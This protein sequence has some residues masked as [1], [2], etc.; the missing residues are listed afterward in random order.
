M[1]AAVEAHSFDPLEFLC[2]R[3]DDLDFSAVDALLDSLT[4]PPPRAGLVK[5]NDASDLETLL[6]LSRDPEIRGMA[7]GR[8][9]VPDSAS[10]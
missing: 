1:V 7:H 10:W 6:A 5:G 3:N 4:A 2:W 9:P 8:R